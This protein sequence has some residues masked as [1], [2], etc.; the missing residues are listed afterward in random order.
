MEETFKAMYWYPAL[1]KQWKKKQIHQIHPEGTNNGLEAK[2]KQ[3]GTQRWT[4]IHTTVGP[5][6]T[7]EW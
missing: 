5:V 6:N 4:R 2:E 1:Q 7:T 3:V